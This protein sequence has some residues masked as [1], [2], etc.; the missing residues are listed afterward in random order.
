VGER[1][2]HPTTF[3]LPSKVNF[4]IRSNHVVFRGR[5]IGVLRISDSHLLKNKYGV[6]GSSLNVGFNAKTLTMVFPRRQ[7]SQPQSSALAAHVRFPVV[8]I[9]PGWSVG[10]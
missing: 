10:M 9:F 8:T 7:F 3:H 4:F 5:I 1:C 2:F 6:I